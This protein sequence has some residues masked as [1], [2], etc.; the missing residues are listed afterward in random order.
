MSSA[1]AKWPMTTRRVSFP[2][3][4]TAPLNEGIT[5]LPLTYAQLA[6]PERMDDFAQTLSKLRGIVP[7]KRTEKQMRKANE[8]RKALF[9]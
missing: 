1:R 7:P 4:T 6:N 5:V 3:R 8:L 2:T 9:G